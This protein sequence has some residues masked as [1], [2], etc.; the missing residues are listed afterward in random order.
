MQICKW[1]HGV[2]N[3]HSGF[4]EI[5]AKSQQSYAGS[6]DIIISFTAVIVMLIISMEQLFHRRS[7]LE[8][9][10]GGSEQRS[11]RN[12]EFQCHNQRCIRAL[13][14]CDGDDDCLD[15]SDEEP[16]SC[17]KDGRSPGTWD[18]MLF[19]DTQ[20]KLSDAA[21]LHSGITHAEATE[22]V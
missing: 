14:K 5:Q 12:D 18:N 11:C 13:W 15:G 22:D 2:R 1:T 21:P 8:A 10:G 7:L 9:P 4:C 19:A 20:N 3:H 16:H 6:G 17:C